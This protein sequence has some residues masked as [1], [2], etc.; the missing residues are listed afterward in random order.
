MFLLFLSQIM[1]CSCQ[2]VQQQE[3]V[4]HVKVTQLKQLLESQ[5]EL[6]LLDVRSPSEIQA[7]TIP[8]EKIFVE[9][10]SDNFEQKLMQ[11]DKSKAYYIYCHSGVRSGNTLN[12]MLQLGFEKV[13]NVEGGIAEWR[14]KGYKIE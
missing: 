7:G 10:G 14:Q 2:Q 1:L 5:K 12:L 4:D 9:Y 6:Y 3:T 13:Y 11:L 8:G